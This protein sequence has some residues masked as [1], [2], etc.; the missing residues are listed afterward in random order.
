MAQPVKVSSSFLWA[1][2]SVLTP[3]FLWPQP[4]TVQDT[5]HVTADAQVQVRVSATPAGRADAVTVQQVSGPDGL[6]ARPRRR[7]PPC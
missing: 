6:L 3:L 2:G 7:A 1:P 5:G 4:V